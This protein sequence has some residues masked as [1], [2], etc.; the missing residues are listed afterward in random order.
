MSN[1]L[2]CLPKS[3]EMRALGVVVEL[4][5]Q[6]VVDV[7]GVGGDVIED[8]EVDAFGATRVTITPWLNLGVKEEE[9]KDGKEDCEG[10]EEEYEC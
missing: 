7:V 10:E 4:G 3:G 9:G 1:N 2:Y 5:L 8:V 6:D